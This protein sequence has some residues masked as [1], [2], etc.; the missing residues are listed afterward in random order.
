M[1][2]CN[3]YYVLSPHRHR[4]YDDVASENIG[5]GP[6][7]TKTILKGIQEG[8]TDG[9]PNIRFENNDRLELVLVNQKFMA[10]FVS[11]AERQ[12]MAGL[13]RKIQESD[14]VLPSWQG[15]WTVFKSRI[16]EGISE[17]SV[18]MFPELTGIKE[19][20]LA[21]TFHI[22]EKRYIKVSR[23]TISTWQFADEVEVAMPT[24]NP[25]ALSVRPLLL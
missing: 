12:V 13:K 15:N 8:K 2:C 17:N 21:V 24:E 19:R 16:R 1:I 18:S 22:M 10:E 25:T 7:L 14:G 6:G 20:D 11:A 23:A 5:L 9:K 4:F 3:R